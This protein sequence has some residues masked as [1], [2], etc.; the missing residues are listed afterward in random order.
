MIKKVYER[1]ED[2]LCTFHFLLRYAIVSPLVQTFFSVMAL[3][4]QYS[5]KRLYGNQTRVDNLIR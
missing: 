5:A 3:F 2:F 4:E 1:T